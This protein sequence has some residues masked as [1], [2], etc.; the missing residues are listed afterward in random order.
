MTVK[1]CKWCGKEMVKTKR[2]DNYSWGCKDCCCPACSSFYRWHKKS[3]GEMP[4]EVDRFCTCCNTKLVRREGEPAFAWNK[5][6][7]CNK[8]CA[9][10]VK[11][12][13]NPYKFEPENDLSKISAKVYSKGSEEFN[14]IAALYQ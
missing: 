12:T 2:T 4:K 11:R 5:R 7:T 3:K 13:P 10:F 9:A 8:S 6:L 14:R 1:I